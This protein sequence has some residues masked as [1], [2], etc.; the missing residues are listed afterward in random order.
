MLD[1]FVH[2][3]FR[4]PVLSPVPCD[5]DANWKVGEGLVLECISTSFWGPF[6]LVSISLTRA[7]QTSALVGR[8]IPK[9]VKKD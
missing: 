8:R 4:G 1:Q 5:S 9:E 7:L 2:G 3:R 6:S